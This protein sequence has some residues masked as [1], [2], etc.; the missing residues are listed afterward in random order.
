[1]RI[2]PNFR[3]F[4]LAGAS[5]GFLAFYF[6]IF[7][8]IFR[9]IFRGIFRA[10]ASRN[11]VSLR[12][13]AFSGLVVLTLPMGWEG[14]LREA[15]GHTQQ[16]KTFYLQSR[17]VLRL[18]PGD[19]AAGNAVGAWNL[20]YQQ[21]D[22]A[23]EAFSNV[24]RRLPGD[25]LALTGAALIAEIKGDT[26]AALKRIAAIV[27]HPRA[28]APFLATIKGRLLV[29][30]KRYA[31]AE[32][33]LVG[34]R[35][36]SRRPYG[37]Y[38][39]LGRIREETGAP[40]KAIAFYQRAIAADPYWLEP[41]SRISLIHKR[42]GRNALAARVLSKVLSLKNPSPYPND[43]IRIFWAWVMRPATR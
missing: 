1:M 11:R 14:G 19:S 12:R 6:V 42:A 40:E 9:A 31:E 7:R 20:E 13:I 43:D 37:L 17:I 35:E 38:L 36:I 27:T 18:N 22:Q 33:V 29:K 34:Q 25:F 32:R 15:W 26:E 10:I 41:Y 3:C 39:W 21:L 16:E 24:L 4:C 8:A 30:Q 5:S 28:F 23:A 2:H